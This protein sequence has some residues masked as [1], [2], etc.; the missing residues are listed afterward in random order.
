MIYGKTRARINEVLGNFDALPMAWKE[1][2][3]R[4]AGDC[5]EAA[6]AMYGKMDLLDFAAAVRT[7]DREEHAKDFP[8]FYA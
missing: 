8:G 5:A 4:S 2:C 7:I 6:V 3:W 1:V